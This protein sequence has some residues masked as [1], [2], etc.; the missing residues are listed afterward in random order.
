MADEATKKYQATPEQMAHAREQTILGMV[1]IYYRYPGQKAID[2]LLEDREL[3][4]V[5]EQ[6]TYQDSTNC[7]EFYDEVLRRIGRK[8]S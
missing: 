8:A 3:A 7:V 2:R 1:E 5:L 6:L 4:R